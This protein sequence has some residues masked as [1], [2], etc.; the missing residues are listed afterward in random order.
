MVARPKPHV[1]LSYVREDA[2]RVERLAADLEA[3]G[4]DTWLDRHQIKPG[5]RWQKA[6]E[7][8]I[9]SGVFFVACF[10]QAYAARTRTHMNEELLIAIEEV[11]LRPEEASWFIPIRLDDSEI[12]DRRIGPELGIHSFEWLD[13]FPDWAKSVD[14]LVEAIGPFPRPDL[15]EPLSVFRD[16]DAPWCPEMVVIP[17]GTF[18]MGSS[19]GEREWFLKHYDQEF[20][21]S[22]KPQHG[23][24]IEAPFAAGRY[25]VT[26]E[27]YDRC[28]AV[29]GRQ[30]PDDW[31]RGRRPVINVSWDNAQAYVEWL[32]METAQRY[33][34]LSEAEWEYACRA[35]TTTRYS[36]GDHLPTPKQANFGMNVG[37]TSEVGSYP[38]NPWGLY[39]M[40]GNVWEWCED[41]WNKSYQGAPRDGSARTSGDCRRRVLRGGSWVNGP[42]GLRSASR[43][44]DFTG[45]RGYYGFGFRVARTLSLSES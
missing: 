24:K 35:G 45:Y 22:E 21:E 43:F 29:T 14:R 10:S 37:K 13:M 28:A 32:S 6:I 5:Q 25:P 16:I 20:V 15:L 33:R 26:F 36:W 34:L 11:R 19:Q 2:A 12:P 1:F 7:E 8:A 18:M 27:E 38:P 3:R 30:R 9:R 44:G 31:G 40:H 17:P 42:E 4:I 39:D 23:V 41:C